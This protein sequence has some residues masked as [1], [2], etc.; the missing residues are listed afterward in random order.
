MSPDYNRIREGVC[1][2]HGTPLERR[3]D[4]GW[5]GIC[6]TGWSITPDT[7]NVH[8]VIAEP[9]GRRVYDGGDT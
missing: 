5:C 2:E 1:P 4:H 8:I 7:V 9:V 3:D 6:R